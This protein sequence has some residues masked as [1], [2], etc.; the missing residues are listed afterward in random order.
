MS[1]LE[2][3]CRAV[4]ATALSPPP[5]LLCLAAATCRACSLRAGP[6]FH[7]NLSLMNAENS[8]RKL[9]T[10]HRGEV[11]AEEEK[12][13]KDRERWRG[14]QDGGTW[15]LGSFSRRFCSSKSALYF[16]SPLSFHQD[17]PM[18]GITDNAISRVTQIYFGLQRHSVFPQDQGRFVWGQFGFHKGFKWF[19]WR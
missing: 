17:P 14:G 1:G 8:G 7:F 6:H 12:A 4:H 3:R 15:S 5:T 19:L 9:I 16:Y 13:G 10:P 11:G 18:N 2:W